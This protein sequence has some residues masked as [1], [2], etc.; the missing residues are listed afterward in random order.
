MQLAADPGDAPCFSWKLLARRR[1]QGKAGLGSL[2][3]ESE[4][5][6]GRVAPVQM[7]EATAAASIRVY[8][9]HSIVKRISFGAAFR[10]PAN[11][12]RRPVAG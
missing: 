8:G 3:R 7:P 11:K 1:S 2:S 4:G 10:P 12:R 6:A 9:I 5:K